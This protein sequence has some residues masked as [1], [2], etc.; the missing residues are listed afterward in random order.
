MVR[1]LGYVAGT[2]TIASFLPQAIRTWRTKQTRDLSLGMFVLLATS[3]SLWTIYGT[4][5]EDWPVVITN[6]AVVVLTLSIGVAKLRY[7]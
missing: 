4:L 5:S 6:G 2:L 3:A 1:Y 7:R